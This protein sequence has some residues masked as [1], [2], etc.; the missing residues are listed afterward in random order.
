[1]QNWI[2]QII[3]QFGYLGILI[4]IL[5]ENI[6]PPIPSEV[7]LTFGGFLTTYTSMN[8]WGVIFSATIGSVLG[9]IIL[10]YVGKLLKPDKME[11]FISGKLGQLLHF[12]KGDVTRASE[13]F[14]RRGK[15]TVFFCRFIPVVR[16]LISIPAGIAQMN[17]ATFLI[18]TT[19]GTFI[20]N[21]V[22]VYLGAIAGASWENIVGYMNNYST[23]A[24]IALAV[25]A[26]ILFIL[27]Y[28]KR[29]SKKRE[30]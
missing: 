13:W 27:Y 18:L 8:I 16:S 3:D 7:I 26:I 4:L 25:I 17:M 20:W 24:I 9:A 1:M 30:S 28:K 11:K 23:I 22:L 5:I 15:L 14:S 19:I 10:Y 29:I 12:K 6:F 21:I 2:I